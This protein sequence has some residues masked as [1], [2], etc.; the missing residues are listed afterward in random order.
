M[1]KQ[2]NAGASL[3]PLVTELDRR[4][5]N[6]SRVVAKWRGILVACIR[7]SLQ[8]HSF[9]T[10]SCSEFPSR[11]PIRR[12]PFHAADTCGLVRDCAAVFIVR[13]V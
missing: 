7:S 10:A 8:H 2:P 3:V 13:P 12:M 5:E 11:T 9:V 4:S 6:H 1:S